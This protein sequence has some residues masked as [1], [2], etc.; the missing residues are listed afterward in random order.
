MHF[1]V[2][3]CCIPLRL[4]PAHPRL[5]EHGQ[6]LR[7]CVASSPQTRCSELSWVSLGAADFPFGPDELLVLCSGNGSKDCATFTPRP[8]TLAKISVTNL[9][10][11]LCIPGSS[12]FPSSPSRCGVF[13]WPE[14]W[15]AA[16][17]LPPSPSRLEWASCPHCCPRVRRALQGCHLPKAPL[18][19][20]VQPRKTPSAVR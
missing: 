7:T 12:L 15:Y 14:P 2:L 18:R 11:K 3:S 5:D 19:L 20:R 9:G 13:P 8:Q 6:V 10:Q 17:G 1:F 4:A 16:R